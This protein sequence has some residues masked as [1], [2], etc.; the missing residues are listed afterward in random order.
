[1][2]HPNFEMTNAA[3]KGLAEGDPTV[4]WEHLAPDIQVENGPGAGPWRTLH[5]RDELG[6]LLIN[7]TEI[8]GGTFHQEG[9]CLYADDRVTIALVHETGTH[10]RSGDAFDNWAIY[11]NRVEDG[12]AD[13][14]WTVDLDTEAVEEFWRRNAVSVLRE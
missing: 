2:T 9:K 12:I 1:M 7:F 8:F 4:A 11:V 3:W 14:L 10:A 13:R 6:E 5:S